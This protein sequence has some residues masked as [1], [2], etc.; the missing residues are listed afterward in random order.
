[1]VVQTVD[2]LRDQPRAEQG[3]TL[4]RVV[5]L[6]PFGV[7]PV[8][9]GGHAAVFEPAREMAL[10]GIKVHLFGWGLRR[11]EALRHW[12][13]FVR[14]LAPNLVEDR[15]VSLSLWL[16]YLK[17]GRKGHPPVRIGDWLSRQ[18]SSR[19]RNACE[20][21]D[22]LIYESPWL[23]P[24]QPS[25]KPTL[26][27]CH[28]V[29]ADLFATNPR[30]SRDSLKKTRSIEGKAWREADTVLCFTDE[31]RRRLGSLYGHR[32]AI[33]VP[34]GVDTETRRTIS[35]EKRSSARS[36]LGL[37]RKFVVLFAGAWHLPN[38]AALERIVSWGKLE[39]TRG[40]NTQFIV[41]GSVGSKREQIGNC[42]ITGSQPDLQEWF[43]AADACVNPVTEGSG[44]NVK[45]LEFMAAGLPLV[46]TP[47]GARGLPVSDGIE[48]LIRDV[49]DFRSALTELQESADLREELGKTA[50]NWIEEN[51]SWKALTGS[52]IRILSKQL[53]LHPST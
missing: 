8:R 45:V 35:E 51:R 46:S 17:R 43:D 18:A 2:P 10:Q 44:A 20:T 19:L 31:D 16:D 27:V 21:A 29:E 28:N 40:S 7:Y 39:A 30:V 38:R 22:A 33:V 42:L 53:D 26:L 34:L 14:P 9:S 11:F 49:G 50:R 15:H 5:V 48:L 3:T 12:R 36:R 25:K 52:R 24:F 41:A 23:F 1:M 4:E 37:N 47:F 6:A 13:S 32:N